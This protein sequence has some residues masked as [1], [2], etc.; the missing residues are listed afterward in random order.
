[1]NP[2][3]TYFWYT[4]FAGVLLSGAVFALSMKAD[5][6]SLRRA[7][8]SYSVGI[9]LALC[10]VL[11]SLVALA[12]ADNVYTATAQGFGGEITVSL[13]IEDGKLVDALDRR[14]SA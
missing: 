9:L 2:D 10:L 7:A 8:V 6:F 5:G 11:S 12:E 13:T 4:F 1:M 3:N 14:L